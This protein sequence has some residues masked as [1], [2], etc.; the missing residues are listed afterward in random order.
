MRGTS[1]KG[2]L[3]DVV[4]FI[5]PSMVV[6]PMMP[7]RDGT[8]DATQEIYSFHLGHDGHDICRP[9]NHHGRLLKHIVAWAIHEGLIYVLRVEMLLASL[10]W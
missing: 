8:L 3:G 6:R 1:E 4:L 7:G 5:E 9:A 10:R 2:L